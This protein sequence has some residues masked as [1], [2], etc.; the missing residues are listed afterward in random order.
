MRKSM[1]KKIEALLSSMLDGTSFPGKNSPGSPD[2]KEK[3]GNKKNDK[4][5]LL[6]LLKIKH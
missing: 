6:R 5:H 4:Y 3:S 1:A 2:E